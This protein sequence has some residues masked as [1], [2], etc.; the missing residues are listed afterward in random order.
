METRSA[1]HVSTGPTVAAYCGTA[2]TYPPPLVRAFWIT[3]IGCSSVTRVVSLRYTSVGGGASLYRPLR[4]GGSLK[5]QCFTSPCPPCIVT[6][7]TC[8]KLRLYAAT[9]PVG[10]WRLLLGMESLRSIRLKHNSMSAL[11]NERGCVAGTG[12]PSS[13]HSSIPQKC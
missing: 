3:V 4:R 12:W 6:H 11:A 5:A 1:F 13:T 9:S 2:A 7:R 8:P 10:K